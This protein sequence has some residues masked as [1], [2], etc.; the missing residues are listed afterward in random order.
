VLRAH[1]AEPSGDLGW[2]DMKQIFKTFGVNVETGPVKRIRK[3]RHVLTHQRGELRTEQQRR[4]YALD[5]KETIPSFVIEL[6]EDRV[7]AMLDE[8]ADAV[9]R[10]DAVATRFTWNRE[11]SGRLDREA[12]PARGQRGRTRQQLAA[13]EAG[14]RL[15][16]PVSAPGCPPMPGAVVL[17][18]GR[19]PLCRSSGP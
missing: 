9:Q 19:P 6:S 17:P 18:D 14:T 1:D 7:L 11:H 13:V 4:R 2:R 15:W 16:E 8:L 10:L 12:P 5:P 3:I